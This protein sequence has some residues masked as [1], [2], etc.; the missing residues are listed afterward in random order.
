MKYSMNYSETIEYI[1]STPKFSR[2]LGND[3]LCRL[4]DKLGNPQSNLRFIHI[5]GTNGKGS[6]AAM[7]SQILTT[8][9][10]KTGL[11]TSPY[12]TRYNER[13][14]ISGVD[15]S[16]EELASLTSEIR[17]VIETYDTPVSEFA[18]GTAVAFK[19]FQ[20]NN[21]DIVILETGLGGR[22]D[23][24]N[25][26]KSPVMSILMSIGLDHTQYLGD[27]IEKITTEKCGIIKNNCPCV[28][29]PN[30]QTEALE[31][32]RKN[33]NDKNSPL[34]IADLPNLM[35]GKKFGYQNKTY[36]LSLDGEFQKYNAATVL[37]AVEVLKQTGFDI[38]QTAIEHGL[39]IAANPARLEKLKC[40]LILDGAHNPPAVEAL[41]KT[42]LKKK[43]PVFLCVAMMLD[44]DIKN[45]IQALAKI[46]PKLV[47]ATT[48]TD[49]PRCANP[50][51]IVKEFKALGI[52]AKVC[53][54]PINAAKKLLQESK[55][56]K[57]AFPL[58]C[59]SLYLAGEVRREFADYDNK[60]AKSKSHKSKIT[61]SSAANGCDISKLYY[62][63]VLRCSDNSLYTGYT[64]DLAR[65]YAEHCSSSFSNRKGAKYTKSHKPESIA[66][67][68]TTHN[69]STALRFE[70][71]I[72]GMTKSDKESL[73]K[74]PTDIPQK[75]ADKN[76]SNDLTVFDIS[77]LNNLE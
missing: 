16:D 29:Y 52:S 25:V 21:C 62:V 5:A 45:S 43:R 19:Y 61:A 53:K 32:I 48:V 69:M 54:N 49:M 14:K 13:I 72:K 9:G 2:V 3:L 17:T 23:A 65:R 26:I 47:I 33:C 64:T 55:N 37:K 74:T 22:L 8:A 41:T 18:L 28:V 6:T 68:W 77:D 42:L 58:V 36:S 63:Y 76:P 31:V 56:T 35:R 20:Q 10:Y 34:Y 27:T 46:K 60:L 71:F 15:I 30:L 39:K 57:N 67:A 51:L 44:K 66:A 40:G 75:Y 38:S 4:L 24:T 7:L 59:G 1:H 70:A 12:I 11:Y 50:K 73:I